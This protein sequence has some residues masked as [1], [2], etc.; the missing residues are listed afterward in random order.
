VFE[1]SQIYLAD[2]SLEEEIPT[3][4]NSRTQRKVEKIFTTW[5]NMLINTEGLSN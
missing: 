1:F 4:L 3:L 2:P 5:K